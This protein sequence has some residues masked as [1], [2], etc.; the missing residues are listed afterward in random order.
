[1]QVQKNQSINFGAS[2]LV[3]GVSENLGK[4][5]INIL[6]SCGDDSFVHSVTGGQ[7]TLKLQT[8]RT[9]FSGIESAELVIRPEKGEENLVDGLKTLAKSFVNYLSSKKIS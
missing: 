2:S 9:D 3:S 7:K 4:K 6:N 5:I 1:M 8:M